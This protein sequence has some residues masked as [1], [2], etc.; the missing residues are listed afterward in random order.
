M[1]SDR[2]LKVCWSLIIVLVHVKTSV[3]TGSPSFLLLHF[4]FFSHLSFQFSSSSAFKTYID[5]IYITATAITTSRSI[6][7]QV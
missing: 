5:R 2:G 4:F 7:K 1:V 6:Y 3:N